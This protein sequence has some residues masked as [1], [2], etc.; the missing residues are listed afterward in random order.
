MDWV[1]WLQVAL[2]IVAV[3]LGLSVLVPA[4]YRAYLDRCSKWPYGVPFI[5][6]LGDPTGPWMITPAF[7]FDNLTTREAFFEVRYTI[8]GDTRLWL[9]HHVSVWPSQEGPGL[10]ISVPP[11]SS[12]EIRVAPFG[13]NYPKP[14]EKWVLT[15]VE[16]RHRTKPVLLEWPKDLDH[17]VD[18]VATDI[19]PPT[20]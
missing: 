13:P 4:A 18:M 15:I 9:P 10:W 3:L 19:P 1:G 8:P 11:K 5:G 14:P 6:R 12:R 17:L 20:F 16:Y 2:A 7:R